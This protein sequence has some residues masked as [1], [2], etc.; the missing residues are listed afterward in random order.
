MKAKSVIRSLALGA[1][2][3]MVPAHADFHFMKVVQLFPGTAAAPDA[4]YVVLQMYVSGQQFVANHELTV[5][6]AGGGEIAS[7]PFPGNVSNGANQATILIATAAAESFF[8]VSADLVIPPSLV[9]EGG[10]VCFAGAVDCV[11]WGSWSGSSSGVG[12][13]F[14]V[15]GGL[16]AGQAAIRRLDIAGSSSVLD[17]GDDTDNCAVDFAFGLPAPRNNAG[18]AGSIPASTCGNAAIEGLEQC[19]DGNAA[20]GDGCS[21]VCAVEAVVQASAPHDFDAD[22]VSDVFWRNQDDGRNVI[23]SSANAATPQAVT[24][25]SRLDWTVVGIGDFN[26]DGAADA[27]WRNLT[28]GRNTIWLSGNASTPQ[29]TVGVSRLDWKMVAVGDFNGDGTDDAFWRDSATGRNVIWLSGNA[30]TPQA[31]TAVAS[32]SW[33]VA[34]AGDFDG[35]GVDDAFWRNVDDGRNAIWLSG[36]AATQQATATVGRLD[37]EVQAV[38]DFNGDGRDDAFWRDDSTGRNAIWLS[39]R[40]ST[41]QATTGVSGMAWQVVDAGDYDGGGSADLF[42]R[43]LVDGRNAVWLSGNSGTQQPVAGVANLDWRVVPYEGVEPVEPEPEAGP[44]LSIADETVGEGDSGQKQMVF[45]VTL[46]FAAS[47][48]VTYAIGT[49]DVSAMAGSDYQAVQLSGETI[50]AGA[51]SRTFSVPILGDT[52]E[53]GTEYFNVDVTNV[54]GG[55]ATVGDGRARGNI[56]EDD[57]TY[58]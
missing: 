3:L 7:Y 33:V 10:K 38:A 5:F 37:W 9:P 46:S 32:D 22:G 8:N 53:E 54:S 28:D 57:Y 15:N 16:L 51:T 30:N 44:V 14:N 43:N 23:W 1:L 52:V 21:N 40:A 48:P 18:Q 39:G 4:Q 29:A 24:G 50:A 6:D 58:Y 2:F 19:D 45:T 17:S 11:A 47:T 56:Q 26:G 13:P 41:Q 49:S 12:T 31:T 27:F 42:W 34:G 36:N 20:N 35:D 25:V 55:N